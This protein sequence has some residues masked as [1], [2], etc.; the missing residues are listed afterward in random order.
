MKT[1]HRMQR[2]LNFF[3]K[4]DVNPDG[5]AMG[6]SKAKLRFGVSG[7]NY[8]L[9][10]PASGRRLLDIAIIANMLDWPEEDVDFCARPIWPRHSYY[11][12]VS[13]GI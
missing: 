13:D 12:V 5:L 10:E 1:G 11:R 3:E 2:K 8:G 6:F 9:G 7:M 4:A